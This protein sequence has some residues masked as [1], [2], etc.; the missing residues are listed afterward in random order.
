M[1]TER[2]LTSVN[3]GPPTEHPASGPYADHFQLLSR[4]MSDD[5]HEG[6]REAL[7]DSSPMGHNSPPHFSVLSLEPNPGRRVMYPDGTIPVG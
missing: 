3:V 7:T 4:Q 6:I 1:R 5:Q 2:G